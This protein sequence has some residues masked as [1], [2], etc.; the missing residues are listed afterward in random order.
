MK[1]KSSLS[2]KKWKE[3]KGKEKTERGKEER[4]DKEE[5]NEGKWYEIYVILYRI[6]ISIHIFVL[7]FIFNYV[8]SDFYEK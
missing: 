4:N 6:N 2:G 7:Y 3:K 1:R 5:V 8:V